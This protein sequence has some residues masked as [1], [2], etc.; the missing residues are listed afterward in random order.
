[1]PEKSPETSLK[2]SGRSQVQISTKLIPK[3]GQHPNCKLKKNILKKLEKF[4]HLK[5]NI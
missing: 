1:V 3:F 4:F 5:E 2:K